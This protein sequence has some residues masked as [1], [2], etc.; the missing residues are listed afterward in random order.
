MPQRL[1]AIGAESRRVQVAG[2]LKFDAAAAAT[3]N[4][5]KQLRAPHS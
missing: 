4:G 1:T 2:N 3:R 5:V